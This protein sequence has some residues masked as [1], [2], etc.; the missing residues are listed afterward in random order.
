MKSKWILLTATLLFLTGIEQLSAQRPKIEFQQYDLKNGLHV[1]LHQDNSSP[2]V[3]INVMY[4]VGS[5]NEKPDRTG[6]AHFFE[7]LMFEGSDNIARG[8]YDKYIQN[9]GGMANASTSFDVTT[10]YEVLPSNQ[11]D[12]GLWLESERMLH[13][14]IDSI[15]VETQRKV[16]KEERKARYE[17]Q[18]YGSFLQELFSTAYKVYPYRWVPIGEDQYIDKATLG[19]FLNFYHEF[20]VPQNAVLVI[21]GD[22]N[23]DSTKMEIEKYFAGIPKG[24][25]SIYRPDMVEPPQKKEITKTVYDNIQLPGIFMGYHMPQMGT[26]DYYALEMLQILL[27]GGK[28]SRLYKELVDKQ[29]K[30][31]QIAAVPLGLED[32]GLFI[33]YSLANVGV[34]LDS[35]ENSIDV[36]IDKVKKNLIDDHEFEK[37]RNQVENDF[38]SNNSTD[39]G[40]AS[41]LADYYTILRDPNLINTLIDKYDAVTK[42][43]IR[44]VANTYL[45]KEN[46]VVLYYLPK[47]QQ[48]DSSNQ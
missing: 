31:V 8:E 39:E 11:L 30:A 23:I 33:I 21:A 45:K 28:S 18:P 48:P 19:E 47:S 43:D 46:R 35:L 20:Y 2:V 10:Y 36:E 4:H 5:K 27:S 7:H 34:S 26:K 37:I 16:V 25:E 40:I 24:T 12:L 1:I 14:K 6:F 38:V 29:Q 17:N 15:G 22:I 41:N 13:L 32:P 9:A 44:R 42:E 3:A